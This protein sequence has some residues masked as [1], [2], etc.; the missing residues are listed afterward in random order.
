[1]RR[2]TQWYLGGKASEAGKQM[3]DLA[4]AKIKLMNELEEQAGKLMLSNKESGRA[5]AAVIANGDGRKVFNESLEAVEA[6][7]KRN[8]TQ[9]NEVAAAGMER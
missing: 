8:E 6:Y 4:M 9:M 7:V 3:L 1:V 2:L 5:E